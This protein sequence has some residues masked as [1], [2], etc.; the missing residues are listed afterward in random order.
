MRF[1]NNA[2]KCWGVPFRGRL[3]NGFLIGELVLSAGPVRDLSTG[4]TAIAV[5][6]VHTC[7]IHD[8]AAKCWGEN[9]F[10]QL[11]DDSRAA[12]GTP[13]QVIGLSAGV[14]A[15][16]TGDNHSCAVQNGE[17]KCWGRNQV[18]QLG[19]N[20]QSDS[21]RPVRVEG[22]TAN[23]TVISAAGGSDESNQNPR[24]DEGHSYSHWGE[25][26]DYH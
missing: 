21:D 7:A 5:G 15:I 26:I 24:A 16:A 22:L 18:G 14:T 20:N 17:A 1:K 23:V 4:V 11:G 10:G 19:N 2:A 3:G 8:G 9:N 25:Y 12:R 6:D 13:V